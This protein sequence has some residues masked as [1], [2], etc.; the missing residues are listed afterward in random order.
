MAVYAV[1][2]M[3]AKIKTESSTVGLSVNCNVNCFWKAW[4]I[5]DKQEAQ[6]APVP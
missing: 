2:T 3:C 5:F 4:G 6:P 1:F